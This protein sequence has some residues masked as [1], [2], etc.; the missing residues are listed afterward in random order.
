[1]SFAV[2]TFAEANAAA[3]QAAAYAGQCEIGEAKKE[4]RRPHAGPASG[5]FGQRKCSKPRYDI[6][7]YR[8]VSATIRPDGRARTAGP[9]RHCSK[10][11]SPPPFRYPA[12]RT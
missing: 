11:A 4:S 6:M 2:D 9:V 7:R 12:I 3:L 5:S 1:M 8:E 10:P